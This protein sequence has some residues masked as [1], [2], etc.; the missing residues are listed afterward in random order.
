MGDSW[1]PGL[2]FCIGNGQGWAAP[3]ELWRIKLVYLSTWVGRTRGHYE[4]W[5]SRSIFGPM[6]QEQGAK[7][8]PAGL[9]ALRAG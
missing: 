2:L 7:W 1:T 3:A 6:L 5:N 9:R 4:R 8:R